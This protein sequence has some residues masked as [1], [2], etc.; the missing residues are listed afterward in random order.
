MKGLLDA[1]DVA[2]VRS[3]DLHALFMR[4]VFLLFSGGE[5]RGGF[6]D[7]Q[8]RERGSRGAIERPVV[9]PFFRRQVFKA[10][11]R[12]VDRAVENAFD[13][14]FAIRWVVV[15]ARHGSSPG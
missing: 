15:G 7:A 9:V 14:L 12:L 4:G 8:E 3:P 5:R 13:P 11:Q 2:V 1:V 10:L 6:G